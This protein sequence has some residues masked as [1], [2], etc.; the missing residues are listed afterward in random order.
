LNNG[1][2]IDYRSVHEITLP[3]C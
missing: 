3:T 2:I 1:G